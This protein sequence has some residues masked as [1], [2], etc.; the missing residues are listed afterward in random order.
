VTTPSRPA[1]GRDPCCDVDRPA[2]QIR[3]LAAELVGAVRV[4]V[5]AAEPVGTGVTVAV[6]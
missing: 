2:E 6:L 1:G 5:V 3:D 4:E